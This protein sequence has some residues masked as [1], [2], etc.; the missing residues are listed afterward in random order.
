[1]KI[2]VLDDYS[3]I[4]TRLDAYKLLEGHEVEVYTDYTQDLDELERRLQG[5]EA[6]VLLRERTPVK[7]ALLERAPSLRLISQNGHVPHIDLAACTRHG[8]MVCATLTSR[9]SY[10]AAELTWG[11]MIAAMRHIP[12]EVQAL[13]EGRWQSTIGRGL[14]GRLLGILGYGRIGEVMARYAT[15]FEMKVLVWGGEGSLA[16]A[17]EEGLE[18]AR[19]RQ[20]FFE[21]CDVVSLHLR[22]SDRTRGSVTRDDLS[23]MKPTALLVNTSRAE[24]IAHGALAEAVKAGRPGMAAVDVLDREP[25]FGANDPLLHLPGVIA[26]PHI[27]YV[28]MD[29]HEFAYGNAFRQILAFEAGDPIAVHNPEV[30]G[31]SGGAAAH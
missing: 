21:R 27:G 12:Q 5:A 9:P 14:R 25:T 6:L 11:L 24:L 20:D 19:S 18:V 4:V 10:A 1:M 28:E 13:R 30:M 17:K 23:R 26:T 15:A 16:K 22:L 29:N 7:E 3:N 31:R 2:V 8:V